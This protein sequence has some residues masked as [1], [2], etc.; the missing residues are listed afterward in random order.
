ME[1]PDKCSTWVPRS[2]SEAGA[3]LCGQ[4]SRTRACCRSVSQPIP[5]SGLPTC[6]PSSFAPAQY[7]CRSLLHVCRR[8]RGRNSVTLTLLRSLSPHARPTSSLNYFPFPTLIQTARHPRLYRTTLASFRTPPAM[9]SCDRTAIRTVPRP[10]VRP[11]GGPPPGSPAAASA[12]AGSPRSSRWSG[13]RAGSRPGGHCR[14]ARLWRAADTRRIQGFQIPLCVILA[15]AVLAY[16]HRCGAWADHA[17][18][19]RGTVAARFAQWCQSWFSDRQQHSSKLLVPRHA[20]RQSA[21]ISV[22]QSACRPTSRRA[23]SAASATHSRSASP[24][25]PEKPGRVRAS[26][27]QSRP[28]KPCDASGNAQRRGEKRW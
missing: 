18:C 10:A 25:S 13:G 11:A 2:G 28:R 14:A 4:G 15:Q 7:F 16:W 21:L 3:R 20:P 9:L 17:P 6:P 22:P 12:A 24:H 8:G 23:S 19:G 1:K 26:A 27:R 5:P